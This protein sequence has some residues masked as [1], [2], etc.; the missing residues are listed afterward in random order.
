MQAKK[1]IKK[2]T[3]DCTQPADDGILDVG[4]FESFLT[5]KVKVDGKTGNLGDKVRALPCP[6]TAAGSAAFSCAAHLRGLLLLFRV[7]CPKPLHR[8][9]SCR[10]VQVHQQHALAVRPF[11][12]ACSGAV[13]PNKL[14][15]I[16]PL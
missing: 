15:H 14:A 10:H 4:D 6:M 16:Q 7:R 12:F 2:F 11:T 13:L 3:I 8:L 9:G 5:T 1:E